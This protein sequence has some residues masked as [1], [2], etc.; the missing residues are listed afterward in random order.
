MRP[1]LVAASAT[2]TLVASTMFALAGSPT[3]EG[4]PAASANISVV[5]PPLEGGIIAESVP[6]ADLDLAAP[7]GAAA[8]HRRVALAARNVCSWIDDARRIDYEP[9]AT[10]VTTAIREATPQI[11]ETVA[12][13]TNSNKMLAGGISSN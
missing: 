6:T 12:R 2:V 9:Y 7:S 4:K 10:C 3:I 11:R 1:S 8:L 13:A 5:R